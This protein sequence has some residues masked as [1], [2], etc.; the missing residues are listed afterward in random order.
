MFGETSPGLGFGKAATKGPFPGRYPGFHVSFQ[1]HGC[2]AFVVTTDQLVRVVHGRAVDWE[3]GD[4]SHWSSRRLN[5]LHDFDLLVNIELVPFEDRF[6]SF[7]A[8]KEEL[9]CL[10]LAVD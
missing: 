9:T 4:R 6:D 10:S 7:A 5:K 2:K 8:G 1:Q 3:P